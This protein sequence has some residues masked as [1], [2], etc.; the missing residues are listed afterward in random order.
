M[1]QR[2]QSPHRRLHHFE[3]LESRWMLSGAEVIAGLSTDFPDPQQ[4]YPDFSLEDVN[5]TSATYQQQA[6]PRDQLG[7]V[8]GW[9]FGYST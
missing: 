7:N 3:A 4:P 5:S 9:Y 1:K 8:S 6:S 2:P